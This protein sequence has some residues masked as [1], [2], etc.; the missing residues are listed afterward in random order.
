VY[1]PHT[2]RRLGL[3]L[4]VDLS[5]MTCTFNCIYCERGKTRFGCKDF[6]EFTSQV[7]MDTFQSSL[8]QRIK[9]G[10]KFDCLTFA[11]TGEPTLEPRLGEFI[12]IAKK[13]IGKRVVKVITNSSLLNHDEVIKNLTKADE[14]IT[15]LNTVSDEVF[16]EMY[17]PYN[18]KLNVER[19]IKGLHRLKRKIK[20][21]LTIEILFLRS[22]QQIKT[23]HNEI[24]V[25]KITQILQELEPGKVQIHT[26]KRF[27]AEPYVL[28]ANK[29]FLDMVS[30]YMHRKLPKTEVLPYL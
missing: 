6:G 3:S 12:K 28:Q 25:E 21:R 22:Y 2:S 24:E 7:E 29:H 1:G 8:R 10:T 9:I 27:P 23:N 26:I 20:K 30:I 5:P 14:V 13:I 17:R 11:G 16:N 4:G 15:K 18:R 19:I